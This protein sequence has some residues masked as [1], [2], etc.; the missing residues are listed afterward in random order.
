M[1]SFNKHGNIPDMN[2]NTVYYGESSS[3]GGNSPFG[4]LEG[5]CTVEMALKFWENTLS[6][7]T[8]LKFDPPLK[9]SNGNALQALF[10]VLPRFPLIRHIDFCQSVL[11][12]A[13]FEALISS[14]KKGVTISLPW[15]PLHQL[16]EITPDKFK[17]ADG[18]CLHA[19]NGGVNS[20][21]LDLLIQFV[22]G[23][24]EQI[25]Q[26]VLDLSEWTLTEYQQVQLNSLEQQGLKIGMI[27][28]GWVEVLSDPESPPR[29]RMIDRSFVRER[30]LVDYSPPRRLADSPPR[31]RMS[32][33]WEE[34]SAHPY[35]VKV[36][37]EDECPKLPRWPVGRMVN[38]EPIFDPNASV[39]DC[40]QWWRNKIE[41]NYSS[42]FKVNDSRNF[43]QIQSPDPVI[44]LIEVVK[45]I[46]YSFAV[47]DLTNVVFSPEAWNML[48]KGLSDYRRPILSIRADA[49]TLDQIRSIFTE[50]PPYVADSLQILDLSPDQSI[51]ISEGDKEFLITYLMCHLHRFKGLQRIHLNNWYLEDKHLCFLKET[52]ADVFMDNHWIRGET[53]VRLEQTM[54]GADDA[55]SLF[56]NSQ[57]DRENI[58]VLWRE[59]FLDFNSATFDLGHHYSQV[60]LVDSP[61]AVQGFCQELINWPNRTRLKLY[62]LQFTERAWKVFHENMVKNRALESVHFE[63][64]HLRPQM[65]AGLKEWSIK[66]LSIVSNALLSEKEAFCQAVEWI[67]PNLAAL[68]LPGNLLNDDDVRMI[69]KSPP[70]LIIL[71][72]DNNCLTERG[73]KYI[74]NP[75]SQE[76]KTMQPLETSTPAPTPPPE[77][78]TEEV[79]KK[80]MELS[81]REKE[82]GFRRLL[83]SLFEIQ[84]VDMDGNCLF[85]ACS[86]GS[87][88][89][90]QDLRGAVVD[91]M[92]Q[93]EAHFA[94][95]IED[96]QS[97]GNYVAS[98]RKD[99]TW[100]GN[101]EIVAL[102]EL[103]KCPIVVL[104]K[105]TPMRV[106]GGKLYP[107]AH[108][109]YNADE[110]TDIY[111]HANTL[112]LY[113]SAESHYLRL[114]LKN[115]NSVGTV[116]PTELA[117]DL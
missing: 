45:E 8:F 114:I 62:G 25:G 115:K 27:S 90:R 6:D 101:L 52:S 100:G 76:E 84:N 109:I 71:D 86:I 1:N 20:E 4:I 92:E 50:I 14:F 43:I 10:E 104:S 22:R 113:R 19:P 68:K 83:S 11:S 36:D 102:S 38:K 40:K 106:E 75:G 73:K 5:S 98:M 116:I 110:G 49:L 60:V 46:R 88:Y 81:P 2:V 99:K 69:F 97:F 79:Y 39:S 103:L 77:E 70:R 7:K 34:P 107:N 117:I 82:W 18:L 55:V 42:I 65:I 30:I 17:E 13:A 61:V 41:R 105:E 85:S 3:A 64:C 15:V 95:H 63:R 44:A 91:H 78:L 74:E 28:R 32:A 111:A 112:F 87:T 31:G 93:N 80:Y 72:F 12:D 96:D 51:A 16:F 89:S 23:F 94:A 56:C 108:F 57:L 47:L 48:L 35:E 24:Y 58:A 54:L 26:F 53:R 66:E 59:Y 29:G 67:V 37:P 9:I 33:F 21:E